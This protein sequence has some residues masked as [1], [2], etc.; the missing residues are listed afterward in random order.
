MYSVRLYTVRIL[1]STDYAGVLYCTVQYMSVKQD[2]D[3]EEVKT[4]VESQDKNSQR[5]EDFFASQ[6]PSDFNQDL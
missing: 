1:Y 6:K 5:L 2:Q 3:Q 4:R